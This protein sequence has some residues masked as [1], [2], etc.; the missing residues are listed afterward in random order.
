MI[1]KLRSKDRMVQNVRDFQAGELYLQHCQ[2]SHTGE[3]GPRDILRIFTIGVE[4]IVY[5]IGGNRKNVTLLNQP[6][7]TTTLDPQK[8]DEGKVGILK[9]FTLNLE[10]DH[11]MGHFYHI[12]H[13][14][15]DIE[16]LFGID[17]SGH[18]RGE[19]ATIEEEAPG[20]G[21]D[22]YEGILIG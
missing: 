12:P 11:H 13:G 6:V 18:T 5:G 16:A 3:D 10:D 17:L 9:Q 1:D 20:E 7:Y 15:R 2:Q 14:F 4:N 21:Y 8:F 19:R 22:Q